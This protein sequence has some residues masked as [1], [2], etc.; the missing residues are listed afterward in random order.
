ME[1]NINFYFINRC[2][3]PIRNAENIKTNISRKDYCLF[4]IFTIVMKKILTNENF[5]FAKE[6]KKS[7]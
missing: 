2:H 5:C 7:F 1:F 4:N 3:K 6:R